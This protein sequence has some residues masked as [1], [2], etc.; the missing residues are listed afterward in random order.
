[1]NNSSSKV[2]GVE[3]TITRTVVRR[4]RKL[5]NDDTNDVIRKKIFRA[6]A[7]NYSERKRYIAVAI[8]FFLT[9]VILGH[10]AV[11]KFRNQDGNIPETAPRYYWKIYAPT[12]EFGNMNAILFHM[13]LLSLI[14]SRLNVSMLDNTLISKIFPLN[15]MLEF[16]IHLGYTMVYLIFLAVVFGLFLVYSVLMENNSSTITSLLKL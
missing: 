11:I 13:A 2:M 4:V 8:H 9:L 14:M 6:V 12:F 5:L 10:F 15:R 1:M 3:D 16:H 7:N